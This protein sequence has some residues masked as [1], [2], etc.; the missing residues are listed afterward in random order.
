MSAKRSSNV[1]WFASALALLAAGVVGGDWWAHRMMSEPA[2][3]SP[4]SRSNAANLP[5]AAAGNGKPL[6]WYDPMIP[7]QHFAKPGKSPMGME[8]VPKYSDAESESGGVRVSSGVIQNLGIRL[9]KV[10]KASLK[11][12]LHAVGSVA[13]DDRLV[14]VVQARVEGYVTHL[15]VKAPLERVHR[16]QP[17]ATILAPQWL[18]AQQEYLALVDA[19]SQ[20]AE[21]LQDAARQRL[22]VLGVP[23]AAIRAVATKHE[24][25]A[26]TT[27]VAPID[28]VMTELGV[29]DGAAFM[30]GA[31][32]FRING[33]ATVWVNAQIPESRVSMVP[34]DSTAE[35]HATAWPG[36]T[37]KGR[38]IALLPQVDPQT[39]TLTVRVAL[40]NPDFQLSPGMWV[41]LDFTAPATEPQL[42]VPSEAVIVTGE[43]SVVIVA[44]EKG[45]FDVVNVSTGIE[46]DGR[47]PIFSGLKEGQSIVLSGQ[48]LIDSEASLT[49]TV[50]RLK[51][52]ATSS[53]TPPEGRQ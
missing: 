41:A 51:T 6:Y 47:T 24:T 25:N 9:G 11:S 16:G 1:K 15:N 4:A 23:D 34:L 49:S 29:R 14:E 30:A 31:S 10:E 44:G 46:Q 12:G 48:F 19:L 2:A 52:T 36:R 7:N 5:G 28:G 22:V 3:D 38:V 37:F 43:R 17:L 26:T 39:R 18:E 42:V 35:A 53:M 50:N 21:A 32:L 45:S 27:L 40:D 8:M 13:F 20:S 33:L